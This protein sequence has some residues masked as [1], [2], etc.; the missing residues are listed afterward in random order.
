MSMSVMSLLARRVF[1]VACSV[2][3]PLAV[4]APAQ[5]F[6]NQR[7][8]ENELCFRHVGDRQ[9]N[10]AAFGLGVGSHADASAAVFGAE[11]LTTE[12]PAAV[13]RR[14]HFDMGKVTGIAVEIGAP[15]QRPVDARRGNLQ[16]VRALD[17]VVDIEYRGQRARGGLAILDR[18]GAVGPL[19]HDLH[20]APGEG[21]N[22]YPHKAIA[23]PSEDR[24][25]DRSDA[26]GAPRL[27]NETWLVGKCR[28]LVVHVAL[29]RPQ[30]TARP[31]VTKKSGSRGNPLSKPLG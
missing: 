28:Q 29:Q 26:R 31:Q 14:R 9:Q 5:R 12:A 18:Q 23:E 20:R 25:G 13:D 24:L 7:V 21:R 2:L 22:A 16:A 8:G 11:Q 10:V 4:L 27:G 6:R 3:L 17:R 19:R 15:H 30:K 1:A